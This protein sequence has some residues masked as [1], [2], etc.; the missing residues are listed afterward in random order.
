MKGYYN[1]YSFVGWIPD[2]YGKGRWMFFASESEYREAY[3]ERVI[4]NWKSQPRR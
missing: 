4:S 2:K 3:N 1:G